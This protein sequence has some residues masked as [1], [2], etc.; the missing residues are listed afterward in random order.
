[1][2]KKEYLKIE[3]CY[4]YSVVSEDKEIIEELRDLM[5]AK[6]IKINWNN[7]ETGDIYYSENSE[8]EYNV[9]VSHHMNMIVLEKRIN[10]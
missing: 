6:G 10:E 2:S 7:F 9:K 8:D 1:M 4:N 5:T 3:N